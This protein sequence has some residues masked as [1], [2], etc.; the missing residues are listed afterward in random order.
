LINSLDY[1][2]TASLDNKP[3]IPRKLVSPVVFVGDEM[4]VDR[5]TP[6]CRS[7][8][9]AAPTRSIYTPPWKARRQHQSSTTTHPHP[10]LRQ[11][12]LLTQNKRLVGGNPLVLFFLSLSFIF[13]YLCFIFPT[14]SGFEYHWG[15][16]HLSLEEVLTNDAFNF[17]SYFAVHLVIS[18]PF[19]F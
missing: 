8:P 14:F 7:T 5:H 6:E 18:F 4:S 3:R 2:K 19:F 1:S 17:V 12:K 16:C 13:F 9:E 15:Q 11:V 10:K